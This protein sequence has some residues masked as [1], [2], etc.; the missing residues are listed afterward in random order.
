MPD[1]ETLTLRQVAERLGVHYMT[2][3]RYVRTGMLPALKEGTEWRVRAADLDEFSATPTAPAARGSANWPVRLRSRMVAGDERGSWLVIESAMAAGLAPERVYLDVLAPA[4]RRIGDD[5]NDGKATIAEEHRASAVAHRLIGRLGVRF[6]A[7]G[8]PRGRVVVGAA[9]GERHRLPVAMVADI[10]RAAGFE[11]IDLGG[12]VPVE[13]FVEA[14]ESV[15][16]IAVGISAIGP[17]SVPAAAEA[18]AAVKAASDVPVLF[19]G[20]AFEGAEHAERLGGDG[21]AAD[22]AE[23][24]RWVSDLLPATP[25]RPRSGGTSR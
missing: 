24:A 16:P 12:D 1:A 3:Y 23:A 13:S 18:A 22:G 2:A 8:R 9:P 4:L 14:V 17:A 20:P 7:R 6:A 5:W 25:A 21:Y 10:L 19:G 15:A 11:V